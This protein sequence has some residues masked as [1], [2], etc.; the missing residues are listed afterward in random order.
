M[1]MLSSLSAELL[2][3]IIKH[4]PQR[5]IA[6][7]VAA[8]K[9][10]LDIG[11]PILYQSTTLDNTKANYHETF[12]LL[13]KDSALARQCT[14]LTLKTNTTGRSWTAWLD[15][16]ALAQMSGVRTLVLHGYPFDS[17]ERLHAFEQLIAEHWSSLSVIE[18]WYDWKYPRFPHVLDNA[19][20]NVKG[21]K[22]VVWKEKGCFLLQG[23]NSLIRSSL[24]TLE[25][26]ILP[27]DFDDFGCEAALP[28]LALRFPKLRVFH[29]GTSVDPSEVELDEPLVDFLRAHIGITELRVGYSSDDEWA[30]GLSED[31]M[32]GDMLPALSSL[33]TNVVNAARLMRKGVQSMK[34]SLRSLSVGHGLVPYPEE[35]FEVFRTALVSFGGL[36]ALERF[37]FN[38]GESMGDHT[39]ELVSWVKAVGQSCLSIKVLRGNLWS[40]PIN[41]VSDMISSFQGLTR[42]ELPLSLFSNLG[43]NC[44]EFAAQCPNLES[45]VTFRG[46]IVTVHRDSDG[47]RVTVSIES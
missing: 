4:L 31:R 43:Q 30:T 18:A 14:N 29:I 20:F 42:L 25:E 45:V 9:R 37:S 38:P 16:D 36:P 33:D 47:G 1:S 12:A 40:M 15:H 7:V 32:V 34:T 39:E 24:E 44:Q 26:I 22:R 46:D 2:T 35:D 28:F 3:N 41:A 23:F 11:R 13:A 6:H 27:S 5:D 10:F 21:L 8:C 19:T 17:A